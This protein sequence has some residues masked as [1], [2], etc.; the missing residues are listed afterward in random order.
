MHK[1]AGRIQARF[2]NYRFFTWCYLEEITV[3]MIA[4]LTSRKIM[5][6]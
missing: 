4:D 5:P 1:K 6:N 3:R 2:G